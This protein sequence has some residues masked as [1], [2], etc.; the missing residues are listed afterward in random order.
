MH[1]TLNMFP[2]YRVVLVNFNTIVLIYKKILCKFAAL[3]VLLIG[4]VAAL[5]FRE[6]K[7]CRD[8]FLD[9]FVRTLI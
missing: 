2:A 3:N 5:G 8:W 4:L 7:I 1:L 9:D 6:K